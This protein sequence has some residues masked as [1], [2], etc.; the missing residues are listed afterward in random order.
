[1][2][3]KGG[4]SPAGSTTSTQSQTPFAPYFYTGESQPDANGNRTY[5]PNALYQRAAQIGSTPLSYFPGQTYASPTDQ[6]NQAIS[7]QTNLAQNDPTMQATTQGMQPYLNGSMMSSGNPAFQNMVGQVGQAIAPSIDSHFNM[8]G[9]AGSGANNQAFASA[10]SNTAGQLA[11]QN[12][13]D[14]STNQLKAFLEAPG[15]SQGNFNDIA[16]LGTAGAQQQAF[17]QLPIT[18]AMN[19]YQFNQDAPYL[20]ANRMQSL[21]TG[22]AGGGT[23]T[24]PYFSNQLGAGLGAASTLFGGSG[25]NGTGP[26]LFNQM[27]GSNLS[28]NAGNIY[29]NYSGLFG[30]GGGIGGAGGSGLSSAAMGSLSGDALANIGAGAAGI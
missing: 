4:S 25:A 18:Q 3:Q 6:Q 16:Q 17:N 28:S 22:G 29:S 13:N 7:A 24:S 2:G 20:Q 27:G 12:Y 19:Q 8:N 26:S 21:L 14:Q 30:L 11:Y 15:V 23:S 1:M 5:D 9:R 10:L